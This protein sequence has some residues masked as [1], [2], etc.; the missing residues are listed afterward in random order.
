MLIQT[1][2][3]CAVHT[4][5]C[6]HTCAGTCQLH[7]DTLA[8]ILTQTEKRCAVQRPSLRMQLAQVCFP[9]CHMPSKLSQAAVHKPVPSVCNLHNAARSL[10]MVS[11]MRKDDNALSGGHVDGDYLDELDQLG[12]WLIRPKLRGRYPWIR[13]WSPAQFPPG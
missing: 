11:R 5:V 6:R 4:G 7:N 8:V 9:A 12:N 3:Q 2:R 10:H 13:I 1:V